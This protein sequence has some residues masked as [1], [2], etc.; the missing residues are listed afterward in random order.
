[1]NIIKKATAALTAAAVLTVGSAMPAIAATTGDLNND[2]VIDSFDLVLC[3]KNLITM[4]SGGQADMLGDIDGNG[5]IQINDLVLL[6]KYVLGSIKEFPQA[7]TTTTTVTATTTTS[8]APV[9]FKQLKTHLKRVFSDSAPINIRVS[10]STKRL[11]RILK[12]LR[13]LLQ[14]KKRP[15]GIL[16]C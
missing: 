7:S 2:G 14:A 15:I 11:Q 1:M 10:A 3:R 6:K 13:R 12:R 16:T 4:F 9:I 8:S 5:S